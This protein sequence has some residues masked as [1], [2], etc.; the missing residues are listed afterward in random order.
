MNLDKILMIA[1]YIAVGIEGVLVLIA[2]Y[3]LIKEWITSSG[4]DDS[5]A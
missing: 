4:T 3:Y 2:F 5:G 1:I